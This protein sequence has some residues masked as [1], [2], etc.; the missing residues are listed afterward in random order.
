M[1]MTS[2]I[3]PLYGF[4]QCMIVEKSGSDASF[5][6]TEEVFCKWRNRVLLPTPFSPPIIK[7]TNR[8]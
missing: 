1:P 6:T 3:S 7:F 2:T 8:N 4:F 5:F